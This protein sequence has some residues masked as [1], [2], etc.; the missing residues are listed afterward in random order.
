M[1]TLTAK[2]KF[3]ALTQRI[4][5][6]FILAPLVLGLVYSGGWPF[7]LMMA[8]AGTI[9]TAEWVALG[10]GPS[11]PAPRRAEFWL[12]AATVVLAILL[13]NAAPLA[14]LG[15]TGT[16]L[17]LGVAW[18]TMNRQ[19]TGALA[20]GV[21]YLVLPLIAIVWLRA[22]PA[23]GRWVVFWLLATVW[24]TD[25]CAYFAGRTIGGPKIAPAF[26]PSKTWA[27]LGGGMAGAA[28]V[29]VITA[30]LLGEN[31]SPWALA[32]LGA[33]LAVV[34]QIG[35]FTESALKRRAGVKDS[36]TLIPGHGGI[37]DRVDGLMF[38]AMV[39][40][41]V[42]LVHPGPSPAAGILIWR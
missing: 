10:L 8:A 36:G 34:S 17:V 25:I 33:G 4:I 5:S 13:I 28:I 41:I 42:A 15:L 9:M 7:L 40:A 31:G 24:A 27:G 19:P 38:A 12:V 11:P 14:A 2:E 18:R 20:F 26:S 3:G 22:D 32:L 16:G 1:P 21:P 30:Y 6:A 39:A 37:L 23:Y 29:G 35:D